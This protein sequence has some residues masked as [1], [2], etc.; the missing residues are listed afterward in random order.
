M[1]VPQR[2]RNLRKV[3]EKLRDDLRTSDVV[4]LF[5]YN[6]TGKT[7]VSM[8][9]KDYSRA[10]KGGAAD[11]LYF[12][13]FT[14]DLFTW[15]NDLEGDSDRYLSLNTNSRF[16]NGLKDLVLDEAIARYLHRYADFEFDIDYVDWKITF[17]KRKAGA[18][19]IKISRGEQSL[20]VWCLFLAICER[21]LDGHESYQWAK[22]L[23]LD[24]PI[25]SLDDNN[26]IAVACDLVQLV[27]RAP[28]R[29][30]QDGADAPVKV[31]LSSHHALFFNVVCNEVG[32]GKDGPKLAHKRYFLQRPDE[33]GKFDL[34]PTEETPFFH[35]VA[36]LAELHRAA[37]P[38][39]RLFT[40]HFNALRSIMEKTASFFGQK[41]ISFCLTALGNG[42]DRAL[43]NRALNL[44]SHGSYAIHEPTEMGEDNKDL[45]RRI[46]V[47]FTTTFRFALPPVSSPP[48]K[49]RAQRT[50]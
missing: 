16:F 26:A 30:D 5:A 4:L 31:V 28:S 38:T 37:E 29:K 47:D 36:L 45:F 13:A 1:S 19:N 21:M 49:T 8:A 24:D 18:R 3:V 2:D 44:L 35:H 46:L 6:R 39:G 33:N 34:Q 9:F 7:R 17:H 25:S 10:K 43:F 14:E 27:R 40:F 48:V 23:Y 50:P 32:R 11:T 15:D 20:F 22:F 12:N 41:D 42:A